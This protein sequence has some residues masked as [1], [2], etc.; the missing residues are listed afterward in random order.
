MNSKT[1]LRTERSIAAGSTTCQDRRTLKKMRSGFFVFWPILQ[2]ILEKENNY[3]WMISALR[4]TAICT[5]LT[6]ELEVD[7]ESRIGVYI[8]NIGKRVAVYIEG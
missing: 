6:I 3:R 2:S 4:R 5:A 7:Q 8:S 1:T